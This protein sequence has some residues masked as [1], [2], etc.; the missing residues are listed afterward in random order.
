[1]LDVTLRSDRIV[2]DLL[3]CLDANVGKNNYVLVLTADHGI[4]P[5]PE[6]SR[7]KGIEAA[8]IDPG[9][10]LT[11]AQEFLDTQF[12][13]RN[14]PG[15]TPG[16]LIKVAA[17]ANIYLDDGQITQRRLNRDE[18]EDA[19]ASWL[20]SQPG[21]ARAYTAHQLRKGI[22]AEDAIGQRV[23]KSFYAERSGDV[24]LVEKPYH[25]L[26]TLLTST[27]HGTPH[28][29]DTHVPLVVFGPG[30]LPGERSDP[31]TPQAA[32]VI[33]AHALDIP[34]PSAA[35]APLPRNLFP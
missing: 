23:S 19:L 22:P 13:P 7:R 25:L 20:P 4:C 33:L 14:R 30:V 34:K 2:R 18:V 29:Y 16:R 9:P 21:V 24:I 10:L 15:Q 28:E 3:D 26:T 31:V 12:P 1:V 17:G 11:R 8:R 6:V 35:E 27:N 32:A 5:L